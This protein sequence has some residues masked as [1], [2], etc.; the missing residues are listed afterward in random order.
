[1]NNNNDDEDDDDDDDGDDNNNN[2]K[3]N[4]TTR[5]HL[6]REINLKLLPDVPV[7]I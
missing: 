6:K 7:I 5:N 3:C 2:R 4:V 1:V